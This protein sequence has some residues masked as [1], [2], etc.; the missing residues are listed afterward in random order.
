MRRPFL[1]LR[2]LQWQLSFSYILVF[3][4]TILALLGIGLAA[5][6]FRQ[7]PILTS[8]DQLV[9]NLDASTL[10]SLVKEG[11]P[12]PS[13]AQVPSVK[14][15]SPLLDIFQSLTPK[16]LFRPLILYPTVHQIP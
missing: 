15:Q 7:A 12:G 4:M 2:K 5:L 9:Q 10:V 16:K 6:V 13:L 11:P 3:I 14:L 8:S 1:P